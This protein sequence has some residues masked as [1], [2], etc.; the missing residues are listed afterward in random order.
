MKRLGYGVFV[1]SALALLAGAG[2]ALAQEDRMND[3]Q[4]KLGDRLNGLLKARGG[5]SDAGDAAEAA[6]G[7][8]KG[9][10]KGKGNRPKGGEGGKMTAKVNLNDSDRDDAKDVEIRLEMPIEDFEDFA[11]TAACEAASIPHKFPTNYIF[12]RHTKTGRTGRVGMADA[13]GIGANYAAGDKKKAAK[14]MDRIIN[15]H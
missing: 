11:P 8:K 15:W 14:E 3:Y 4:R 10:L 9:K 2:S 1:I 12:L 5:A 6:R 13:E 7:G